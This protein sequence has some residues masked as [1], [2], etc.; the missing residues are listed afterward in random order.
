MGSGGGLVKAEFRC[1][2]GTYW[3]CGWLDRPEPDSSSAALFGLFEAVEEAGVG[4]AGEV[5]VVA[6][7]GGW[8]SGWERSSRPHRDPRSGVE[9]HIAGAVVRRV[10]ACGSPRGF[11]P[12]DDG[13]GG[14]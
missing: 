7:V 2:Y 8:G 13:G 4:G 3:R 12:R 5:G 11:A 14:L 10:R 9:I 6:G 1:L